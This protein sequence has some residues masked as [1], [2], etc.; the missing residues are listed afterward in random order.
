MC[1]V[2]GVLLCIIYDTVISSFLS[3]SVTRKTFLRN[4]QISY[5]GIKLQ[6]EA[7]AFIRLNFHV[8]YRISN[9]DQD[10]KEELSRTQLKVTAA[11]L[12]Q[13][14][15]ES[16]AVYPCPHCCNV[17]WCGPKHLLMKGGI[18]GVTSTAGPYR[19][20]MG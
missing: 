12:K 3:L 1:L 5:L 4:F 15:W 11:Q 19:W 13:G 10:N 18:I 8:K 16:P 17:H 9:P 6:S 2:T 14:L 20:K 7:F